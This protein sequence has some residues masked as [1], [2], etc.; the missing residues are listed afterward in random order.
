VIF[1]DSASQAQKA[2]RGTKRVC[3]SCEVRFYD[4]AR[5]PIVCPACGVHNR[6][7]PPLVLTMGA[8]NERSAGKTTWRS[9]PYKPKP[10]LP[11]EA[12]PAPDIAAEPAEE[13]PG[14][15]ADQD[16]VLEQETDEGDVTQWVDRDTVET[17]DA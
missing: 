14:P 6:A 2:A 11:A 5:D 12:D 17:K 7:I 10:A 16:L 13:A 9:K 3:Q 8:R 1:I 15:N 4:L